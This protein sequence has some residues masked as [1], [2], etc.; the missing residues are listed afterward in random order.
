MPS[1]L[2]R[3]E[4]TPFPPLSDFCPIYA[5]SW[6]II[7]HGG[8]DGY[9]RLVVYLTAASNNTPST[10]LDS[11]ILAVNEY[12]IPEKVRSDHGMWCL[13]GLSFPCSM[14]GPPML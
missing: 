4:L 5:F 14:V 10:V 8:I 6:G 1:Y 13:P 11:F 2:Y 3:V 7:T 12:G 9:S